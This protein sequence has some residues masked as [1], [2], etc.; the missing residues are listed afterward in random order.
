MAT[1]SYIPILICL[2]GLISHRLPHGHLLAT[3][4][5]QKIVAIAASQ[6]H[7]RE[8]GR[9]NFGKEV[10]AY[11]AYTRLPEGN[12][13]CAAFISWV[14]A[15]AGYAEPRTAWS[16]DLFPAARRIKEPQA[17]DLLA[18]YSVEKK[19]IAHCGLIERLQHDWVIAIEGNT[20]VE[21]SREGDGVYRKWRHR[22]TIY[23]Y[24][25]WLKREEVQH[26]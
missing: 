23:S 2:I 6:L 10:K 12:P 3:A 18:I 15:K 19:R 26:D 20:N 22:K 1:T 14:F 5:Q 17:A 13:Y 25:R 21:G 16:P 11:L 7:V 9:N 8:S 4:A 24:S